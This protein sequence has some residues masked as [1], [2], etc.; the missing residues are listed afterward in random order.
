MTNKE[1]KEFRNAIHKDLKISPQNKKSSCFIVREEK[2]E[3]PIQKIEFTFRNQ[4][5]VLII[6]QKE[7]RDTINIL[8]KFS[9]NCSCDFIIFILDKKRDVRVYFCEIKPSY[10]KK[11]LEEACGQIHSSKLFLKYMIECYSSFTQN[12][13]LKSCDIESKSQYYYI[14][15]KI[16]NSN[17]KK[18][19]K[20]DLDIKN[21]ILKPLEIDS[22]AAKVCENSI[23]NFFGI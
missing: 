12:N 7:N 4:D 20:D 3:S 2:K 17:K 23:N 16:N 18:V 6:Q 19:Y 22:R 11:Y 9:T 10:S 1:L 15:P 21:L 5:D 8:E 13:C 14:Y